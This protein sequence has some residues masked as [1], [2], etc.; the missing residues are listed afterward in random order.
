MFRS[1]GWFAKIS[2]VFWLPTIIAAQSPQ[3]PNPAELA[4]ITARGRA[5]AEYD[6]A[7]WHATDAVQA[8][9]PK[10]VEG[11]HYLAQKQNGRWQV[12]FGALD[13]GKSKFLI[14]YGADQLTEPKKFSITRKDPA[15]VDEAFYL[16]A[17][18][19]LELALADFGRTSRPYNS[20]VLPVSG[21]SSGLNADEL[22]VYLYPA[23]TKPGSYPLGGDI[24]YTISPDGLR[25]VA[26]RQL[27]KSILD[28]PPSKMKKAGGFH[29]H[30]L[31]DEPEDTDVLHVLQQDPPVPEWVNTSH[32]TYEISIDGAIQ[33]KKSKK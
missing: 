4:A 17:A 14:S 10:T 22:F 20:A 2:L 6:Q 23:P 11:Q 9:N 32:F 3:P 21:S 1:A 8:A 7:E 15:I 31:S 5:L 18:R 24:R 27:H 12:V 13:P 16:H 30:A 26:K 25:I 33:V 29:T 19:A 28:P